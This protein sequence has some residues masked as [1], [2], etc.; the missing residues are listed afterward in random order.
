VDDASPSL[1][2]LAITSARP[3]V[4]LCLALDFLR[5]QH[6]VLVRDRRCR[7]A[8]AWQ[9]GS[10]IAIAPT[11]LAVIKRRPSGA[12][13]E[14][15][16]AGPSSAVLLCGAGVFGICRLE[17]RLP[18]AINFTW[19]S[20]GG[21]HG[22]I[23][24]HRGAAAGSGHLWRAPPRFLGDSTSLAAAGHAIITCSTSNPSGRSCSTTVSGRA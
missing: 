16:E 13:A 18:L 11:L 10:S 24:C 5:W 23:P 8:S 21:G 2:P 1:S 4:A 20:L 12:R 7:W 22:S 15:D 19:E 3:P 17:L 14:P 6:P 9:A